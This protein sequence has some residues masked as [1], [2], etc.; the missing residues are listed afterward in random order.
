M[1]IAA[2][3]TPPPEPPKPSF[4]PGARSLGDPLLPQIGNGGYNAIHYDIALDYDRPTNL[5]EDAT[6]TMTARATQDLSEFSLDFQDLPVDGVFVDGVPAAFDQVDSTPALSP[7]PLVTQPMK[8]V[9]TPAAGSSAASSSRSRSTTTASRRCSPTPTACPRG[10]SRPASRPPRCETCNSYFVVGEPMGS[11]A[12]FP[13][14]NFPSDKATFDTDD[15]RAE[16]RPGVRPR[17]AHRPPVDNGDGTT[18]WSWS[19]DDPTATYLATASNGSFNYSETTVSEALSGRTL[20]IY[21]ALDPTATA[22][23][24]NG[25]NTLVGRNSALLDFFGERFGPYPFDSYGAIY[26]RTPGIGYALEVQGKSHFSVLPTDPAG[27]SPARTRSPTPTSS[28]TSG[29]ATPSRCAAGTTSGS[30]RAG[31]SSPNGSTGTSSPA[32]RLRRRSSSTSSTPTRL[33]LVGCA[34][35]PRRRP[36]EPVPQRSD[37]RCAAAMTLQAYREILGDDDL[38]FDFAKLIQEQF[39][40]GNISTPEFIEFAEDYADF[41]G[42]RARPARRVLPA[43]A[44]RDDEA[45]DHAGRLLMPA[46]AEPADRMRAL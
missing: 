33:R 18:T 34:G 5:F 2:Q 21:N 41:G 11:Q 17:R 39:E 6:V 1:A 37:V 27:R 32:T 8:L 19:E 28:P 31:P 26:D 38:F 7:D 13:S 46:P 42:E 45:D 3:E 44:V 36:G 20:P 40:Y 24:T 43:V 30:T 16:Q 10:G 15:H 12:W 23:Q 14:N 35:H 4:T 22:E 29:S 25:V 9:V